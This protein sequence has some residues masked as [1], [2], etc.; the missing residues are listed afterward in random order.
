M[1]EQQG[2]EEAR[3]RRAAELHRAIDESVAGGKPPSSPREFTDQQARQAAAAPSSRESTAGAGWTDCGGPGRWQSDVPVGKRPLSWL[4][5][6][7]LLEL[8]HDI[9]PRRPGDST[10]TS[11]QGWV[12]RARRR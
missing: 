4:R 6:R 12:E 3:R 2:E 8:R 9:L 5:A 1:D 7:V 10:D 11:P